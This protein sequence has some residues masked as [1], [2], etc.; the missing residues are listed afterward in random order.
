MQTR[1]TF[2]HLHEATSR[3]ITE[4]DAFTCILQ[5]LPLSPI[6]CLFYKTNLLGLPGVQ[7]GGQTL[8]LGFF[9][10][11]N[12]P[13]SSETTQNNYDKTRR[14]RPRMRACSKRFSLKCSLQKTD[15]V[16]LTPARI[17][18][19]GQQDLDKPL[20]LDN[21]DFVVEVELPD[22][23]RYLGILWNQALQWQS[24]ME[25]L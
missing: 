12:V 6:V 14:P 8:S 1:Q 24:R 13:V 3:N 15:L 11:A 9:D 18:K 22:Q 23:A 16:H 25:L 10:N 21:G 19:R 20:L 4:T 5:G 17:R 7:P 2:H